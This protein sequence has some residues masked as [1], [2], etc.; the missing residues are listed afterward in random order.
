MILNTFI[1]KDSRL[2][3]Y[4]K[5]KGKRALLQRSLIWFRAK[6]DF[7]EYVKKRPYLRSYL[8]WADQAEQNHKRF[9]VLF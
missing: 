7:V 2:D 4:W 3:S 9:W 1:S 5:K 8:K 6:E